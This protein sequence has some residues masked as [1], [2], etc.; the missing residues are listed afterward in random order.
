MAS[1]F[2]VP[3]PTC[4]NWGL[5]SSGLGKEWEVAGARFKLPGAQLFLPASNGKAG[6]AGDQGSPQAHLSAQMYLD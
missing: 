3:L 6:A 4:V 2:R 1:M 5:P